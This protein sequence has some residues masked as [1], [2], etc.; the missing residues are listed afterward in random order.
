[1]LS[2]HADAET[3]VLPPTP[4][5]PPL[6]LTFTDFG[7]M[8]RLNRDCTITEKIDGCTAQ[9]MVMAY[10]S[11]IMQALTTRGIDSITTPTN[12]ILVG[13]RNRY[14]SGDADHH[15][16]FQWVNRNHMELETLG[17]GRHFG[18]WWG[19]G[20]Q[21]RYHDTQKRFSLFNTQRWHAQGQD[22][23]PEGMEWA[24]AC[25][26]VVP[27]LYKGPFTTQAVEK[28]VF[29]LRV[30]G[31]SVDP[32]CKRPEGVIVFHHAL[33]QAFKVT[34]EKDEQPKSMA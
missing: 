14:L 10:S 22:Y 7:K 5:R 25:C 13:S 12:I 18:E 28:T 21:K 31:S 24:P 17:P 19:K 2:L 27:I 20:I 23:L 15:G 30:R 26:D 11:D 29:N 1:M 9:I 8:V 16:F 6:D 3:I 33:N 34:L 32:L 4:V